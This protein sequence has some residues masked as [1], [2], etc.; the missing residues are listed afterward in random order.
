MTE[1]RRH[2]HKYI[3]GIKG[4]FL[5]FQRYNYT[6]E[7]YFK[8]EYATIGLIIDKRID[9]TENMIRKEHQLRLRARYGTGYSELLK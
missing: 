7:K 5:G 8:E 2:D 6:Y 9:I 1:V 4:K 3:S